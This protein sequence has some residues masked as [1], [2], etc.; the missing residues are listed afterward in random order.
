MM[1]IALAICAIAVWLMMQKPP[2]LRDKEAKKD[3]PDKSVIDD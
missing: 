3:Q 2:D 1:L